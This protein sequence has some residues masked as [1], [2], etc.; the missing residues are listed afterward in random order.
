M[1]LW[2]VSLT[3]YY[4]TMYF[5]HYFMKWFRRMKILYYHLTG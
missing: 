2:R 5:I 4:C 1:Q 3:A